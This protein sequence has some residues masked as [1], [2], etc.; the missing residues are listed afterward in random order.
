MA[1]EPLANSGNYLHTYDFQVVPGHVDEFIRMFE[2]FDYSDG[3][4]IH[5]SS[6][7]VKDGVLCCSTDDRSRLFLIAEWADTEG[8]ARNRHIVESG[9]PSKGLAIVLGQRTGI[10]IVHAARAATP[11]AS[12]RLEANSSFG[13]T[14]YFNSGGNAM[15]RLAWSVILLSLTACGGGKS[16]T[17]LTVICSGAGGPQL[18]GATSIDVLGDVVGGRP[19][20]NYPDP[21]NPGKTGSIS[22]DP[23]N[24]CK[25]TPQAGS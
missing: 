23:R 21:A 25:I 4:W 12:R 19:T 1:Q 6:A 3:K 7:Q 18:V 15:C 9:L 10:G 11:T 17:T 8:H 20:M 16:A 5:K 24:H 22:I 14:E 2:D 13:R